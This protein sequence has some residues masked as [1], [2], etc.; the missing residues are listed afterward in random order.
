[1]KLRTLVSVGVCCL[2]AVGL[3]GCGGGVEKARPRREVPGITGSTSPVQPAAE[4]A[5]AAEVD[6]E[7][8]PALKLTNGMVT[9]VAVPAIGGRIIEYRIGGHACLW[10]N[11]SEKGK[12]YPRP[13]TENDRVW[14]NYGGYGVWPAPGEKWQGP[15]DPLGSELDSGQW[16]GKIINASGRKAEIELVS[17][18]DKVTGLQITRNIKLYG[19]SS[20]LRVTERF[21]NISQGDLEWAMQQVTWLPAS[22]EGNSPYNEKSRLYLPLNTASRHSGGYVHLT[23]GGADQLKTLSEGVLQLSYLG[24]SARVGVDTFDGWVAHVDES[25]DFALVQRFETHKLADY[26]EQGSTVVLE[27]AEQWPCLS[28]SLLSPAR[29]L[30]TGESFERVTDWYATAVGGPVLDTSEVAAIRQPLKIERREG[31]LRLTGELG[32]FAA[33]QLAFQL[34]DKEGKAIGQPLTVEASPAA[35]VKLDQVLPDETTAK[36]LTVELQN[37]LGTPLGTIARLPAGS[38]IAAAPGPE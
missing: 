14:R 4:T 24:Q 29:R 20:Q 34:A 19:G 7:G 30:K 12:T 26:P 37:S 6:Y 21:T 33:G 13:R 2:L 38:G 16:T 3:A 25:H 8:W 22:G 36:T 11:P 10:A 18:A 1:M 5:T 9:V 27:S 31:K 28:V 35:M 23:V 15:P 32:V 17:P